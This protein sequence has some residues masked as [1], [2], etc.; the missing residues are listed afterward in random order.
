[1]VT[2]NNS[3]YSALLT[4]ALA[5]DTEEVLRLRS[6][7]DTSNGIKRYSLLIRWLEASGQAPPK[8]DLDNWPKETTYSLELERPIAREDVDAAL[9]TSATNPVD[10]MVTLDP[11]GKVGWTL[12]DDYDFSSGT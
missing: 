2:M 1:M 9:E 12:L 3:E 4:A 8:V 11:D 10:T 6:I 7:I 5:G